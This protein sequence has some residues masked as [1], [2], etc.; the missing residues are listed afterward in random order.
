MMSNPSQ[1]IRPP[2][3][4]LFNSTSKNRKPLV[5]KLKDG[6]V[7]PVTIPAWATILLLLSIVFSAGQIVN[8]LDE[9]T[10]SNKKYE[11]K[12]DVLFE[13]QIMNI[14]NINHTQAELSVLRNRVDNLERKA[15][16]D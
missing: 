6:L 13:R 7:V 16:D 3:G 5:D 4:G 1:T 8:K 11:Q 10:S 12:I 2:K 15:L 14:A 9:M